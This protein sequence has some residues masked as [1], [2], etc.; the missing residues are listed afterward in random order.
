MPKRY[1]QANLLTLIHNSKKTHKI[2][3]KAMVRRR[4]LA[5]ATSSSALSRPCQPGN[6]L[7]NKKC[8]PL[9]CFSRFSTKICNFRLLLPAWC[10]GG[11]PGNYS[12]NKKR[13]PLLWFSLFS[14]KICNSGL[15]GT[16]RHPGNLLRDKKPD[17]SYGFRCFFCQNLKFLSARLPQI[18]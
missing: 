7:F 2:V 3:G 6:I 5:N 10:R 12:V 8:L 13:I 18:F 17:P 16:N 15:G 4:R 14:T 1:L 9:I 11:Q